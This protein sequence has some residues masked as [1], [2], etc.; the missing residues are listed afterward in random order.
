MKS[1]K[2]KINSVNCQFY[3]WGEASL[4]KLFLFH[5]WLDTGASFQFVAEHLKNRFHCI[6]PDIRGFGKSEHTTNPLGYSYYEFV[7]D[8]HETFEKLAPNE[9]VR[10]VGH[11]LGGLIGY[12]YAGSF[13]ERV[14]SFVN[15][16]GFG[17]KN[18]SLDL[19]PK[20][21]RQWIDCAFYEKPPPYIH[22]DLDEV[23]L[24]LKLTYP[25]VSEDYLK[26]LLPFITKK[27]EQG[28]LL[29]MDEKHRWTQPFLF[30]LDA[31]A[32]FW[33]QI[34]AQCL[35]IWGKKSLQMKE[36]FP[37]EKQIEERISYFPT[38]TKKAILDCGHMIHLEK[39]KELAQ[40][41]NDFNK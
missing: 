35:L 13:P 36:W 4:P 27:T 21:V 32:S 28:I 41:I 8:A 16:E 23:L 2:L 26:Q 30:R 37:I 18:M 22:K 24:K 10:I 6:A 1:F 11:S 34:Q 5:T 39:P 29:S 17:I 7:A 40:L 33:K 25:A 15:I 9:K 38:G 20:M 19:G 12:L 14:S 3:S 31:V